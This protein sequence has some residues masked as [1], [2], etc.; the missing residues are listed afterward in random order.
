MATDRRAREP[1]ERRRERNSACKERGNEKEDTMSIHTYFTGDRKGAKG[2]WRIEIGWDGR[3]M[4]YY[5]KFWDITNEPADEE[6]ETRGIA[7]EKC[8]LWLGRES[9]AMERVEFLFPFLRLFGE[10][11]VDT[12]ID[13]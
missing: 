2:R 8:F 3:L 11:P 9:G 5:A 6:D 10:C 7:D 12:L 13:L 1:T 4:T